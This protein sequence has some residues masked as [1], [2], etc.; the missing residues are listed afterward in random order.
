[1]VLATGGKPDF[2]SDNEE[3]TEIPTGLEGEDFDTP[4]TGVGE[5]VCWGEGEVSVRVVRLFPVAF[6]VSV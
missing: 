6:I 3:E 2:T 5:I 4:R 1:V